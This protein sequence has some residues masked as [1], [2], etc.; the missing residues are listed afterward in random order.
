MKDIHGKSVF[1]GDY[2]AVAFAHYNRGRLRTGIVESVNGQY[3]TVRWDENSGDALSPKM[4]NY[5]QRVLVI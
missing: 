4:I 1:V 3:F 2:V 5:A